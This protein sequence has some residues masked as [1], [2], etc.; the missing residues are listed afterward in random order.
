MAHVRQLLRDMIVSA[1]TDLPSTGA[2]VS[3]DRVIPTVALPSLNIVTSSDIVRDELSSMDSDERY[4]N[5]EFIVEAR[6]ADPSGASDDLDVICDE[7]EGA[8]YGDSTIGA[9][10]HDL[11]LDETEYEFSGDGDQPVGIARQRWS[12]LL[13]TN[14]SD[15][16]TFIS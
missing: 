14:A 13:V 15:P 8:L 10:V 6:A 11:T 5:M 4:R 1:L 3:A 12:F 9:S 2:N 7:I 16:T